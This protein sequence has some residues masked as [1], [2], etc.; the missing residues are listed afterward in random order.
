MKNNWPTQAECPSFYG[1]NRGPSG[2]SPAWE[3]ANL[4]A[5]SLPWAAQASWD[6]KIK[7]RSLRVHKKCSDSLVRILDRI[8]T[9][10]GKS[11]AN[12]EKLRLHLIGGSYNWR[13]MTSS[14][15]LSMHSYGC[16]VDIDPDHNGYGDAHPQLHPSII[17]AF[18]DE[19]WIW[20][21]HWSGK[22]KDGQHFQAA[23]VR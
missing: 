12:I 5:V 3:S 9:E 14:N 21:G 6:A 19:S 18:E 23:R 7:I 11:Q 17:A 15:A 2:P 20:G 1:S 16:A 8:W 13:K 22:S 4:V 10:Q